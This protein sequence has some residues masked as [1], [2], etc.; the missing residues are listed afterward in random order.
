MKLTWGSKLKEKKS[1]LILRCLQTHPEG[2][3]TLQI[4]KYILIKMA[5]TSAFNTLFNPLLATE[6]HWFRFDNIWLGR[7][8][9]REEL[10]T[11]RTISLDSPESWSTL[12]PSSFQ[13]TSHAVAI[14]KKIYFVSDNPFHCRCDHLFYNTSYFSTHFHSNV[15]GYQVLYEICWHSKTFDRETDPQHHITFTIH[16]NR[17]GVFFFF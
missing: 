12:M 1:Y 4:K 17:H 3:K 7:K 13:L 16:N 10:L 14:D 9:Q 6:Q 11:T 2:R 15:R 5:V 8:I